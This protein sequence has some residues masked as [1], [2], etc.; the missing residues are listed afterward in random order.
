MK[1]RSF[2]FA[3]I[4]LFASMLPAAEPAKPPGDD[5][6]TDAVDLDALSK[7]V[8]KPGVP[9]AAGAAATAPSGAA[10]PAAPAKA[11]GP[12]PPVPKPAA[13]PAAAP[14]SGEAA[15]PPVALP[16]PRGASLGNAS[17]N[18]PLG[19]DGTNVY[20][21]FWRDFDTP[22][23][24][25]PGLYRLDLDGKNRTPVGKLKDTDRVF[26]GVQVFG[27]SI[28]F[29]TMDGLDTIRKDGTKLHHLSDSRVKAM[30]IVGDAIYYQMEVLGGSLHRMALDGSGKK[31][32]HQDGVGAFC[33][34]D[35]KWIYYV[36]KSDGDRLWRMRQDG[37][38]RAKVAEVRPY[39]LLVVDGVI[40]FSDSE[41]NN[42]LCRLDTNG[43]GLDTIVEEP[44]TML[45]WC[46]G[47]IYFVRGQSGLGRCDPDGTNMETIPQRCIGALIHNGYLFLREDYDTKKIIRTKLDGSEPVVV[48][49]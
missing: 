14:A 46:D 38:Q 1:L 34:A 9:A 13:A 6:E 17:Q 31:R 33:V 47:K 12:K 26:E 8:T 16:L 21:G 44:V 11:P 20:M 28:Y 19:F 10:Q 4:C 22:N 45:N 30:A 3:T 39:A 5:I 25:A 24:P 2:A 49:P 41:K 36:N 32:L 42:A 37:T 27:D 43:R 48:R 18:C 40:W 7:P 29:I 15:K 23:A 35:D